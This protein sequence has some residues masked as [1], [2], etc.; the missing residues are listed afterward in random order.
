VLVVLSLS[1]VFAALN[2]DQRVTLRFGLATL[3]RVP[4]TAV[5]FGALILGVVVMLVA[6]IHSDLKVRRILRERLAEEDREEKARAVD[7]SQRDLFEG[8]HPG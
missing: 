6:G 5:V 7:R 3:Y 8:E 2:G 4:V 1:M